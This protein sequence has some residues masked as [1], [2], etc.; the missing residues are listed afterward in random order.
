L[1]AWEAEMVLQWM[2][3]TGMAISFGPGEEVEGL[4]QGGWRAGE[5]WYCAFCPDVATWPPPAP[6]AGGEG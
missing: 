6:K 2:E 1:W 3:E 5:W 4:W